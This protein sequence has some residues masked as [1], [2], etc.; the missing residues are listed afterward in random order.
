MVLSAS[1]K[2]KSKEKVFGVYVP[3]HFVRIHLLSLIN[4]SVTDRHNIIF[5]ANMVLYL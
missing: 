3:L 1:K 4:K 2:D 5:A